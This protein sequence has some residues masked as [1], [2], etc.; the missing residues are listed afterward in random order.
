MVYEITDFT[1]PELINCEKLLSNKENGLLEVI[2][3]DNGLGIKRED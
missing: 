2:V 3:K 1:H